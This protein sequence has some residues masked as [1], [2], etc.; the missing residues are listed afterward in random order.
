MRAQIVI[1]LLVIASVHAGSAAESK[2]RAT[3]AYKMRITEIAH[4]AIDAG[5]TNQHPERSLSGVS[6]A[7]RFKVDLQGRV[8]S[9]RVVGGRPDRWAEKAAVRIL[10]NTR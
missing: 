4:R 6:M 2:W 10:R 8:Q 9:V 3:L 1:T 7:L 5:L